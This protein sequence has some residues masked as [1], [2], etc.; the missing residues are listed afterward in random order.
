M[1]LSTAVP[2]HRWGPIWFCCCTFRR[3]DLRD[4]DA[5]EAAEPRPL[6]RT[7]EQLSGDLAALAEQTIAQIYRELPTYA[8]VPASALQASIQ[9]NLNIALRALR[10]GTEPA[11]SELPQA[12]ITGR[13][14]ARQGVPVEDTM[15]VWRLNMGNVRRRFLELAA[16]NGVPAKMALDG[17]RLLW[18]VSDAFT[19]CSAL[20]Y[21]ELSGENA[22]HDAHRQRAERKANRRRAGGSTS[23]SSG[24]GCAGSA[25]S[26]GRRC[27]PQ[28]RCAGSGS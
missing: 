26:P 4:S 12:E 2:I 27:R 17:A 20:V 28:P 3:V 5:D 13:E 7:I 22:L 18:S 21:Q 9:R 24:T 10:S 6:A 15:R 8:V 1:W 19:T 23:T 25:R 16:L 11:P 14:R